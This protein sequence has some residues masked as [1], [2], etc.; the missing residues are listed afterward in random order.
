MEQTQISKQ[1]NKQFKI[2]DYITNQNYT[3]Q[4]VD[5]MLQILKE[6][7]PE[8]LKAK[9]SIVKKN[10]TGILGKSYEK[11]F[12]GKH[13]VTWFLNEFNLPK[14]NIQK[15][16]N[17]RTQIVN[18]I[19]TYAMNPDLPFQLIQ[20][21]NSQKKFKF[22]DNDNLYRF[23]DDQFEIFSNE[24]FI[25][26]IKPEFTEQL[27][28]FPFFW[29]KSYTENEQLQNPQS[30]VKNI[31]SQLLKLNMQAMD[32]KTSSVD[33]IYLGK[34]PQF[35]RDLSKDIQL[36]AFINTRNIVK[37]ENEK[38]A[39]F[40]NIYNILILHSI[41]TFGQQKGHFNVSQ[42]DRQTFYQSY[43]YNIGGCNLTLDDIEHGILRNNDNIG[44]NAVK[45]FWKV[46]TQQTLSDK[47][48]PRFDQF[49]PRRKL[50]KQEKFDP[51]VHF[52][53]NCGVKSCPPIKVYSPQRL[54]K[55]LQTAARNFLL[56]SVK[57]YEDKKNNQII[58]KFNQIIQWY[59]GDFGPS[60]IDVLRFLYPYASSEKQK[61]YILKILNQH[62]LIQENIKS[63]ELINQLQKQFKFKFEYIP[64]DWKVNYKKKSVP[65]NTLEEG[66]PI[67]GYKNKKYHR[68]T[69]LKKMDQKNQHFTKHQSADDLKILQQI[70]GFDPNLDSMTESENGSLIKQNSEINNNTIQENTTQNK[71]KI[72]VEQIKQQE[73]K[74]GII[75]QQQQ[76]INDVRLYRINTLEQQ[77]LD[78]GT[79]LKL[80]QIQQEKEL[81][82]QQK[83]QNY[84]RM[85][86]NKLQQQQQQQSQDNSQ[87]PKNDSLSNSNLSENN[88]NINK[89]NLI[90]QE[91]SE[92]TQDKQKKQ[93]LQQQKQFYLQQQLKQG[94]IKME[95]QQ[96]QENK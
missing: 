6:N 8:I 85:I 16:K 2:N 13:L 27:Q 24:K 52:T 69:L 45:K 7:V 63:P 5:F 93:S 54:E 68:N 46:I 35:K 62:N 4:Q 66:D 61:Y 59:Q 89:N 1:K 80:F 74:I 78:E 47:S 12:K 88:K 33:Y 51:R 44:N 32:E 91:Q 76:F 79:H 43:S 26:N 41:I 50:T 65:Q 58:V 71:S 67:G 90:I 3:D 31:R 56:K 92:G 38:T 14:I 39:F 60:L 17:T 9:T 25:L 73:E 20:P 22:K 21:Y 42:S 37:D 34:T 57:F 49:D 15:N 87:I 55:Q 95:N 82:N 30:I 75:R 11:T 18:W 81:K 94:Q 23:L 86:N 40:I 72:L 10:S 19:Q 36:L 77:Q 29:T 84:N 70:M 48:T 96:N 28:D 53:L 64:Y 83:L